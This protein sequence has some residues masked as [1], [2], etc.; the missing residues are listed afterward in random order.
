MLLLLQWLFACANASMALKIELEID[1][2]FYGFAWA[3]LRC[4][5]EL[6]DLAILKRTFNGRSKCMQEVQ[7]CRSF[8]DEVDLSMK[9]YSHTCGRT[10][11]SMMDCLE[12][13][14]C[15]SLRV[16]VT[17]QHLASSLFTKTLRQ[18]CRR[19]RHKDLVATLRSHVAQFYLPIRREKKTRTGV[20]ISDG[21]GY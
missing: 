10:R 19:L 13:S 4:F 2:S 5:P 12:V 9:A 1:A 18:I 6:V 7:K 17:W 11:S 14:M 20:I 3:L 15:S 16:M 8:R 21:L